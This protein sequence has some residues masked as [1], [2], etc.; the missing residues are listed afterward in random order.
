LSVQ[1]VLSNDQ[2]ALASCLKGILSDIH[3]P[4]E[5]ISSIERTKFEHT[6]FYGVQIVKVTLST[7]EELKLFLKD[8]GAYTK[9]KDQMESRRECELRVYRDLLDGSHLGTPRYYGCEWDPAAGRYWLLIELVKGTHLRHCHFEHWVRSAAWIARLQ[10]YFARN[11]ERFRDC[12]FLLRHDADYFLS[13]VKPALKAVSRFSADLAAR[14]EGIAADYDRVVEVMANQPVTFVH[15]CYT[16]TQILLDQEGD[17]SR[18]CPIDWE[19]SALG[20]PLYDLA[21]LTDGFKPPKLDQLW[22]A[23]REEAA[24]QGLQVPER[25]E[26]TRTVNCFRLHRIMTWLSKS[27][28][29]GYGA[30]GVEDLIARGERLIAKLG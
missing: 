9:A 23:Y 14:L 15:G 3:G 24:E 16:P 1:P 4:E 7:G 17:P 11:P 22:D 2:E 18:I 12:N 20:S 19:R 6:T 26:M 29:K 21:S 13:R 5:A 27:V 10:G 25:E 28:R 8:F 30:E